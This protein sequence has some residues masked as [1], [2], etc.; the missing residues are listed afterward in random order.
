VRRFIDVLDHSEYPI[1]MHCRRGADRTGIAAVIAVLLTTD[2]P[3]AEARNQLGLRYGHLAWGR[4]GQ[5]DLMFDFYESWLKE[6][7][8]THSKEVFRDWALHSYCPGSCWC[9]LT[10]LEGPPT[11][12]A[13]DE[14]TG[15]RVRAKNTSMGSWTLK[16]QWWAGVHLGCHIYDEQDFPVEVVKAGLR[17]GVVAPGETVDFL[18]AVPALQK[19]GRYRLVLDMTDEQQCWFYQMG[20]T[21]LELELI[22]R[23]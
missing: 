2:T 9:E 6:H 11:S 5:L 7:E 18:I 21:P 12:V 22:V 16:P 1:L 23:E 20:S 10:L 14:P 15:I 8:Q 13:C 17:D 3:L 19:A 4:P